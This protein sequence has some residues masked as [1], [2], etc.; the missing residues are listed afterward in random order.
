MTNTYLYHKCYVTQGKYKP[1][2]EDEK[3]LNEIIR[4][5]AKNKKFSSGLEYR[6]LSNPGFISVLHQCR[7]YKWK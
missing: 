6:A 3:D 5:I 2:S 4:S 7:G 1:G